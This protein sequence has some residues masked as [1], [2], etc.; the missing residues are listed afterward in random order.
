MNTVLYVSKDSL[1]RLL[2]QARVIFQDI[3]FSPSLREQS[4]D[5]FNGNPGSFYRRLSQQHILVRY[6]IIL[7]IHTTI[8]EI[9]YIGQPDN[10]L[11]FITPAY[12]I[13][14]IGN[15]YAFYAIYTFILF[16]YPRQLQHKGISEGFVFQSLESAG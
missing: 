8:Y 10:N 3:I 15:T 12:K 13:K 9:F 5:M 11:E 4:H 6:D 14:G 7:P 2:C 1:K 16:F